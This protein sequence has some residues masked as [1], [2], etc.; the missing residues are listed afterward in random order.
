MMAKEFNIPY[1]KENIIRCLCPTCP[2]Q[3]NSI[4]TREKM[5]NIQEILQGDKEPQADDFPGLYCGNGEAS[6]D[7]IDTNKDC[8]CPDCA[9]Y[10]ENGLDKAK[11][12]FL[13]CKDGQARK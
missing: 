8:V 4:C 7:D 9:V 1:I 5:L 10:K 2:V 11:P 3:Q 13:Y 12:D 6:C